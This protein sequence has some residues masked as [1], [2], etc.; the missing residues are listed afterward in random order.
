MYDRNEDSIIIQQLLDRIGVDKSLPIDHRKLQ[1]H[2][3]GAG[4]GLAHVEDRM[5]LHRVVTSRFAVRSPAS[6]S[7][8]LRS[9]RPVGPSHSTSTGASCPGSQP[10]GI[11]RRAA[12]SAFGFAAIAAKTAIQ[13]VAHR[14]WLMGKLK[15]S[16]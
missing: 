9:G 1:I 16:L 14:R 10:A 15:L 13:M 5:M 3:V 11:D 2:S 6:A 12:A 7:Q 8:T 4:Q